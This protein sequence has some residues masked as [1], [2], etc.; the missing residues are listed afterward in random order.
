VG[1]GELAFEI[2]DFIE[3]NIERRNQSDAET[4]INN[5]RVRASD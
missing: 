3:D 5:K 2:G 1:D 4:D